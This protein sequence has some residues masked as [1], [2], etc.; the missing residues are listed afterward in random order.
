MS[1]T[2]RLTRGSALLASASEN[3]RLGRDGRTGR[4]VEDL[5]PAMVRKTAFLARGVDGGG[6]VKEAHRRRTLRE[7][8]RDAHHPVLR[9]LHLPF[10]RPVPTPLVNRL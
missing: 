6:L 1:P 5:G 2:M 3:R 4:G 10:T 7:T 8:T 9:L